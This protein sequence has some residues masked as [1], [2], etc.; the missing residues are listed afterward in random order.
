MRKFICFIIS[1][2]LLFSLSNM[3]A[4]ADGEI[5]V[6]IDGKTIEFDVNPEIIEGRT[7]VPLR[8][9]FEE[10]GALVKWNAE[11]ETVSARKN[12]KTVTLTV[13]SSDLQID[14]GKTD[15]DGNP[16]TETVKL[17]VPAQIVSGRTL[18]PLRAV[19]ESFGLDVLWDDEE[20][21][22]VI[23]SDDKEDESWKSNVGTVN[24]DNMTSKGDGIEISGNQIKITKGG[25]FTVKG[26][27][28]DG[29]IIVS[30]KEKVKLRLSGAK[31]T[32]GSNPC[33]FIEKA[34]K[35]YITISDGTENILVAENS[36]DGAIYSKENLEIKGDGSLKIESLKGHGIKASDNLCIENGNVD[37]DAASDGIHINDTFEMKGGTVNITSIGDGI[38]SESILNISGGIIIIDTKGVPITPDKSDMET[39]A[40]RGMWGENKTEVEF[41][42]STKGINAEWM[43]VISGGEITV[44]SAS[45]AIHCQD[46]IEIS[47]GK[48]TLNSEYEKGISAHGNL[49]VSGADTVV[50][51]TKSTEGIESKNVMTI[52]EGSITVVASDD[53]INA[54]GGAGGMMPGAGFGGN[55]S[56]PEGFE[57]GE[58]N[59]S[60]TKV[61]ED[62]KVQQGEK[63]RPQ[64]GGFGNV[65]PDFTM[66]QNWEFT[67]PEGFMPPD[68]EFA[69]PGGRFPKIGE[70]QM[71]GGFM[72][73]MGRDMKVCLI[74]NGGIFELYS[75]D[76]CLDSNG[77]MTINSATIKASNPTG[78]FSG[79][80]GIIDPDGKVSIGDDV[81]LIF[82][83][84]SGSE[85]S[86]ALSAPTLVIH[87]EKMR[88]G[89]DKIEIK[90]ANGIVIYELLPKGNYRA[91][92]ISSVNLKMGEKY[93]VTAGDEQFEVTLAEQ[94]TVVGTA[95]QGGFGGTKRGRV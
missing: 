36:E 70:G 42:K 34:D 63:T 51:V 57:R 69:P 48:L 50:D 43:M 14:K 32:S 17:E 90:D 93:F 81:N 25:D 23:T 7:M 46:E 82:A 78:A 9:I 19:S 8:K 91:L 3:T 71:P 30:A 52:N 40:H 75:E 84:N 22:I 29:N 74:I 37:I 35:A 59:P 10:I 89:N 88:D 28:T 87:C 13:G 56:P 11:T 26:T 18:V 60:D 38:D 44:N 41:E 77:N 54:T 6:E 61:N 33:I 83:A 12:K 47:G 1:A 21:K 76:D 20:R 95:Q 53:A 66:P 73:G 39:T 16:V 31:I 5:T 85:R 62:G 67:P 65:P 94:T 64:R 92:L 72:G 15:D 80:F 55:I 45:H 86:L 24:L 27:L 2:L 58:R 49:T 79:A 68:G 4:L